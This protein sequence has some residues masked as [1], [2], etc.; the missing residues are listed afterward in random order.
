M[1]GTGGEGGWRRGGAGHFEPLEEGEREEQRRR[2][3]R[4]GVRGGGGGEGALEGAEWMGSAVQRGYGD[5]GRAMWAEL[6]ESSLGG[7]RAEPQVARRRAARHWADRW[8]DQP[9]QSP[10]PS[11]SPSLSLSL[12]THTHIYFMHIYIIYTYISY[13][14]FD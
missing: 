14:S 1:R 6:R 8:E 3:V 4:G 10:S 5:M 12:H 13:F 9:L 2:G 11:P 7:Q